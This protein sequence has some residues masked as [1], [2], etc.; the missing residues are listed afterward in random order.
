MDG[1]KR[2]KKKGDS[3]ERVVPV[4]R[5]DPFCGEGVSVR[6]VGEWVTKRAR[7]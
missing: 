5:I 1:R 2:E 3:P 7:L 6:R 4:G